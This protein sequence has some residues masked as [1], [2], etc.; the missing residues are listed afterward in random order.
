MVALVVAD[1]AQNLPGVKFTGV[2]LGLLL[3]VAA[4]RAMFGKGGKGKR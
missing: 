1:S 3:L 4:I 2:V